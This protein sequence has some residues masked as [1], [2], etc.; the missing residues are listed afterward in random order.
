MIM[1]KIA[2]SVTTAVMLVFAVAACSKTD[3]AD[4]G[5]HIVSQKLVSSDNMGNPVSIIPGVRGM[6]DED[7]LCCKYIDEQ[8]VNCVSVSVICNDISNLSCVNNFINLQ[9]CSGSCVADYFAG[10]EWMDWI[11]SLSSATALNALR[12]G[13]YIIVEA[14]NDSNG[15]LVYQA[16]SSDDHSD[17]LYSFCLDLL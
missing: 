6:F 3:T 15:H 10:T 17:V 5:Q 14:S 8:H 2:I 11:P 1:K 13:D 9:G 7:C 4:L 16:V 12:S